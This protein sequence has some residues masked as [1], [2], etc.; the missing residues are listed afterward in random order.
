MA[1]NIYVKT[2]LYKKI[3]IKPI[4]INKNIRENIDKILKEE[5]GNKCIKEGYV[6]LD[7]INII[8]RSMG[9]IGGNSF[10]GNLF[11]DIIYSANICNPMNGNIIRGKNV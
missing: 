11:Y 10:T 2:M 8:R 5:V 9:R 6:K 3:T 7:S 4:N 1:N